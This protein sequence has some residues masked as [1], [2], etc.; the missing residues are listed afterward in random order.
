MCLLDVTM[1]IIWVTWD[2]ILFIFVSCTVIK[3]DYKRIIIFKAVNLWRHQS[4]SSAASHLSWLL[5]SNFWTLLSLHQHS[6]TVSTYTPELVTTMYS[7]TL[8]TRSSR[9]TSNSS[10]AADSTKTITCT[11]VAQWFKHLTRYQWM[12]VSRKFEPHF[13]LLLCHWSRNWTLIAQNW[14]V[15][16]TD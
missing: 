5:K 10:D 9:S 12:L 11:R 16:R 6:S 7:S 8:S 2:V 1:R 3:G 13:R 15:P 4:I 14:L